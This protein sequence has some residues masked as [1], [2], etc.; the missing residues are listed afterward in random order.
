MLA[1]LRNVPGEAMAMDGGPKKCLG[2]GDS[3]K[4]TSGGIRSPIT[5]SFFLKNYFTSL[6]SIDTAVTS[7]H[8]AIPSFSNFTIF[9]IFLPAP[10]SQGVVVV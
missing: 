3:S 5:G 1:L 9:K 4:A 10:F 7:A 8:L 2:S 6:I